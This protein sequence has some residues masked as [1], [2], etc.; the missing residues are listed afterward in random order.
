MDEGWTRW[1]LER[2]EF[3]FAN[4][5]TAEIR[6]GNLGERFDVLIVAADGPGTILDGFSRGSVPPRFAGGI[7]AA[8]VRA[9]DEFVREGG[10]LVTFN[11]SSRFAIDELHLP[12]RDVVR[13]LNRED[14]FVSGSLLEVEV[15][16]SHPV[17]AGMPRRAKVFVDRSP[18]F[19]T[20]EGFEGTALAK[21]AAHGS[22]LLSGY[23][24]GE[25][26]LQGMAAALDVVHGSGH[27]ILIGFRP[28]WRGQP[29]GTFRVVFNAALYGGEL[30]SVR[31]DSTFWSR[32]VPPSPQ[33]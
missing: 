16:R 1:L 20:E 33:P 24:L 6:S 15:D 3:R 18:V 31:G 13:D 14:F 25:E 19:T 8:G 22:P 9:I 10:T 5:T 23:L 11:Q 26:H 17:M 4:V 2:H 29:F 12:V 21:Y 32:P 30:A 7:G 28:Q 27:V